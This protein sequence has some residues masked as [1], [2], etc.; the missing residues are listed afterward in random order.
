M[1]G[2]RDHVWPAS[3]VTKVRPLT[4]VT[5]AFSLSVAVTVRRS[6]ASGKARRRQDLPS[7]QHVLQAVAQ[8]AAVPRIV[9]HL[10]HAAVVLRG[11]HGD[12]RI[13]VGRRKAGQRMLARFEGAD[14]VVETRQI[15]HFLKSP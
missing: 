8:P 9:F 10:E 5:V 13:D 4:V 2:L 3:V 12:R 7:V 15:G 14:D 1:S 11:A 6:S